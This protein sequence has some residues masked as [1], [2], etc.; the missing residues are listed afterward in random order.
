MKYIN[1]PV[2]IFILFLVFV[3]ITPFILTAFNLQKVEAASVI[4]PNGYSN[5]FANSKLYVDVTSDAYKA[6]TS[7]KSSNPSEAAELN[8][9][10]TTPQAVWFG[11]WNSDIKSDVNKY[12]SSANNDGSVPV[13]VAYNIPLRDC[14]GQSAGGASGS[15]EYKIW[16]DRFVQG[17]DNRKAVVIFEPDGLGLISC[18]S[19]DDQKTRLDLYRYSIDAFSTNPNISTYID[20]SLWVNPTAM[21]NLLNQAGI[22][23]T[24]GVAVNISGYQPNA[25]ALDYIK[26]LREVLSFDIHAIIDT[27]RNGLTLTNNDVWCNNLESGLGIPSTS[28]VNDSILDAYFWVKRPGE[29]DGL[30]NSGPSAG[31]WWQQ[32]AISLAKKSPYF[33]NGAVDVAPITTGAHTLKIYAAGTPANNVYPTLEVNVKGQKVQTLTNIVG[34]TTKRQFMEFIY[35]QDNPMSPKDITLNFVNDDANATEDRNVMVDKINIDGIDY[36]TEDISTV[37]LGSWDSLNGCNI[38][39]KKSEWLHCTGYFSYD[40]PAAVPTPSPTSLPIAPDPVKEILPVLPTLPSVPNNPE[41]SSSYLG[42]YYNNQALNGAAILTRN[43]ADLNFDWGSG[44]PDSLISNDHFSARWTR[45]LDLSTGMYR[46]TVTADDGIRVFLDGKLIIDKFINQAPTTYVIE[47]QFTTADTHSL[48]IEY[49]ENTGGAT[50]KF[51]FE[52]I[53]DLAN[54]NPSEPTTPYRAQYYSNINLLGNPIVTRNE[55]SINFDWSNGSP[56]NLISKDNF[57][58]RWTKNENLSAGL[59]IFTVTADDGI[60][61][62]V[63]GVTLIDKFIDQPSSTYTSNK[64]LSAGNHEIKLEYYERGG[65]AVSKFNYYKQ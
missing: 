65:S 27:S 42:E 24:R 63:D 47:R 38:G 16:I 41:T 19:A 54:S 18:N 40:K 26:K 9:I 10:A 59:Y 20:A 22:Q 25:K 61:V 12:V 45:A 6:Y 13:L 1:F 7:A 8:K 44:S 48:K 58:A 11:G 43:D 62:I 14:N 52:K 50:M 5:L 31:Q 3:L 23:K 37:S 57:S 56:D 51:K 35:S 29:S 49:F 36:Q 34:D 28:V 39:N 60:R 2:K 33:G 4:L 53:G 55:G 21:A 46:F 15:S 17:I 32:Y 64:Y 30:C